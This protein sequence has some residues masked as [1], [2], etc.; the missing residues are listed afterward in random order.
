MLLV[1]TLTVWNAV[2]VNPAAYA[3]GCDPKS[4]GSG[5]PLRAI[6]SKRIVDGHDDVQRSSGECIRLDG[7]PV[8]EVRSRLNFVA[9]AGRSV[10]PKVEGVAGTDQACAEMRAASG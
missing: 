6:K 9:L 5:R 4:N 3:A 2:A 1:S 7:D 8:H 10:Q